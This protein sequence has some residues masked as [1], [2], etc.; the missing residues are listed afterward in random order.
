M[1]VKESVKIINNVL[2]VNYRRRYLLLHNPILDGSE[3]ILHWKLKDKIYIKYT[4][5]AILVH[6]EIVSL[7]NAIDSLLESTP[8]TL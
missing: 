5:R 3:Y 6:T 8:P 2:I 7:K 4:K 1:Y